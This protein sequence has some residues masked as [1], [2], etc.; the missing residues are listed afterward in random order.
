MRQ[1]ISTDVMS[2][3]ITNEKCR[4]ALS[5]N[6]SPLRDEV[7]KQQKKANK[8][9]HSSLTERKEK[10]FVSY[11]KPVLDTADAAKSSFAYQD[12]FGTYLPS[13]STSFVSEAKKAKDKKKAKKNNKKR[14]KQSEMMRGFLDDNLLEKNPRNANLLSEVYKN[15]NYIVSKDNTLYVYSEDDGCFHPCDRN[16]ISAEIKAALDEET[17]SKIGIR[18]YSEAYDQLLISKELDA[19]E[20]FFENRPFVNCINGVVDIRSGELLE[21]SP[22]F[23]FKHCIQAEYVPGSECPRF[24]EYVDYITAGDK[25]L[26]KLLRVMMGYIFSHYNNAKVAFLVYG[27]P[28]TGKS[29]LCNL[30]SRIIGE[31]L[32]C[33]VDISMLHHQEYAAALSNTLLNISPDLKNQPLKDV[34]FFKSL[35][36][37]DDV[38][39][40]RSLYSN[41]TKIK[42]E[43]KMVFS[44]NHLISFSLDNI[45]IFDIEATFNRL[46]YFPFQN[47]PIK[48]E[49][50]NKHLSEELYAERDAIFTWAMG[51][52]KYYVEHGEN[53]PKCALSEELKARNVAQFCPEKIFFSEAIKK[54]AGKFESSL[55]IK[56]AFDAFCQEIGAKVKGD[57]HTYLIEHEHVVKC[58]S[59]KRIDNKGNPSSEGNPVSV[60][61]GIRLRDKFKAKKEN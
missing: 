51:G 4:S 44:S 34:G 43:A 19:D 60:Y 61:E 16:K 21:H 3:F 31:S 29:V 22:D 58:N 53:F 59:K 8:L 45:G 49:Q 47:A 52:L 33:N 13:A 40:A 14:R 36:S 2:V 11:P 26:K 56:E 48:D 38:I 35:V 17:K 9:L 57:I 18:D 25:E 20:G 46:L 12:E 5:S 32:V 55:A 15:T 37:K 50:N 41:P 23:R 24:M 6:T 28:H 7:D 27:I 1:E 42:C 10:F 54:A 39:M 30:L